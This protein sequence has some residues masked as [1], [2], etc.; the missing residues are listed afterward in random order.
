MNASVKRNEAFSTI[1]SNRPVEVCLAIAPIPGVFDKSPLGTI[2]S[3][4][5]AYALL[6]KTEK[7]GLVHLTGNVQVG[8]IYI[9]NCCKCCCGVLR[10]INEFGIPA[11]MVINSHYYAEIDSEACI[12]CGVCAN[13]RCQVDAI[14]EKEESFK[15]IQDRCIG[16]GL[17]ITTCPVGAIQLVHKNPE[18]SLTPPFNEDIWLEERGRLRGVDFTAYK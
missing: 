7:E 17:C 6:R 5:E 9:C 4:D 3:K 12:G 13:E 15:I 18:Q 11:S 14:E 8:Q 10:A 1:P 2:I 16:C